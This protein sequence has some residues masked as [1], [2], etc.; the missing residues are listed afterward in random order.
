M[1]L[2][3]MTAELSKVL[4]TIR[5]TVAIIEDRQ[6]SLAKLTLDSSLAQERDRELDAMAGKIKA[7]DEFL[8]SAQVIVTQVDLDLASK[9]EQVRQYLDSVETLKQKVADWAGAPV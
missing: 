8:R 9:E 1:S 5:T 7:V 3:N 4:E 6:Q 2:T